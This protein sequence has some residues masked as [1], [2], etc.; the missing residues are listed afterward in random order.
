MIDY[1][2]ISDPHVGVI[3][4]EV[5][6]EVEGRTW[7]ATGSSK[8]D[9]GDDFRFETGVQIAL[10]RALKKLG[11][12]VERAGHK[13]VA[14]TDTNNGPP[15]ETIDPR[16][17]DILD[18]VDSLMLDYIAIRNS[19][20]VTPGPDPDSGRSAALG[21]TLRRVRDLARV[22][23]ELGDVDGS[24]YAK[25]A[26]NSLHFNMMVE[27]YG[28]HPGSVAPLVRRVEDDT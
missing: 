16:V 28:I 1:K 17:K 5:N 26:I 21:N 24:R 22:F 18:K 6:V 25:T 23:V 11:G 3:A 10:G 19:T 15:S 14:K 27:E 12:K 20:H 2:V 9:P 4:V 13:Y 8:C 7:V